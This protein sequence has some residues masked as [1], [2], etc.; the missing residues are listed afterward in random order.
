[1][2]FMIRGVMLKL[3]FGVLKRLKETSY[4]SP[5]STRA[6]PLPGGAPVATCRRC[7]L[8]EWLRQMHTMICW[9]TR[10]TEMGMLNNTFSSAL[11]LQ[12]RP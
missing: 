12:Q 1:M 2:G 9:I 6:Q 10:A 4:P 8:I 7:S 5:L 3:L 11:N